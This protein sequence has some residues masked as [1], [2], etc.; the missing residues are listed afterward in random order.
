M[1][2]NNSACICFYFNCQQ[3]FA[4]DAALAAYS[5]HWTH[6]WAALKSGVLEVFSFNPETIFFPPLQLVE[7]HCIYIIQ[8]GQFS[9]QMKIYGVG[10]SFYNYRLSN[11]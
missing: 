5:C 3:Y 1:G 10:V 2:E 8:L 4:A 7:M 9:S 11:M 6:Y